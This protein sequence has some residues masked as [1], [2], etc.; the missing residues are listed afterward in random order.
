ME[1]STVDI[2]DD[3]DCAYVLFPLYW[4]ILVDTEKDNKMYLLLMLLLVRL[5]LLLI[6]CS[7]KTCWDCVKDDMESLGLWLGLRQLQPAV[8]SLSVDAAKKA[9]QSFVSTRLDY[10]NSLMYGIADRLMQRLQA[11]Q[12]TAARLITGARRLD[13]ISPVLRQ[14]HWLPVHQRVQFKLA[15]LVFKALHGQAPQ[16]LTDD[17]QLVAAA[18]C[19]QLWSSEHRHMFSATDPQVPRRSCV[20]CCWTTSVERFADQLPSASPL[21]WDSSEGR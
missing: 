7:E 1:K 11:I 15:V 9:V 14:L 12:N 10:C 21:P 5:L 13:H 17:C 3:S 8:R 16:C 6:Q 19:R 18:G 2:S 20:W 4:R